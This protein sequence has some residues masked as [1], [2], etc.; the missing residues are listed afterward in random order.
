MA[1]STYGEYS[2]GEVNV[3]R[4]VLKPGDICIDVG[5]NIGAFTVPMAQ[6]VGKHGEVHAF[7]P[8]G[9]NIDLLCANVLQNDLF[10][11]IIHECA[12]SDRERELEVT[13]QDALH[14]Y[15]HPAINEGSVTVH[16]VPIDSLKLTRCKLIKIDVDRHE[17]QVIR[18]ARETIKRCRPIIYV[19]NEHD[20]LRQELVA[21][22]VELGY[23]LYW[24]KPFQFNADN[25]R[26]NDRN[27]FGNLVSIMNLCVP[28][29][30]GYEVKSLDEVSDYRDDD[31]MFDREIARYNKYVDRNPDDLTSRLMYA[32]HQN[33]MQRE[34]EAFAAL[35]ENLRREPMHQPSLAI[36]GFFALQ[37]GN[38]KEGWPA[39]ELRFGQPNRHQFGGDRT[40]S[41]PKWDGSKTN[42][43]LLIWS[44]QGFGDNIMFAR[45]FG[46][47]LKRAPMAFLEC[48]P[49][50]YELFDYSRVA[51]YEN[52]YRL[53]RTLPQYKLH[54]SICSLPHILNVDDEMIKIERPYLATDPL[55]VKNWRGQGN[56]RMGQTPDPM[57]GARIGLC[58]KGS[59]T[60]ERPYTR[61]VR[62][63]ALITTLGRKF[64]PIFPLNNN[65]QFE[66]FMMTAAAIKALDI[67]ITV[68]TSVA[69]LA[70]ALGVETWLLLSY[71]PDWRWGLKGTTSI[72]YP[73]MRIFRQPK[74][75]DWASVIE[76]VSAEL[77]RRG[78]GRT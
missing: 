44:E 21:E 33:L 32:H 15:S 62:P 23:R 14:A 53:G 41:V 45:F 66:S 13:R 10:N 59:A 46:E 35:A 6:L 31:E 28:D 69:H 61:D 74:F 55:L 2:E 36:K 65:G 77:E 5:A 43:P 7:E 56:F 37:R 34:D 63:E 4:K 49:E 71:D 67:V 52:L 18:G 58:H 57:I 75:R 20:D 38:W 9:P 24:H 11:V 51:G 26:K 64:G 30:E 68:D 19:E 16:G 50:L 1:L 76:E 29:E 73:T 22:L 25:W 70:G 78:Y 42:E 60:S 8:C 40:H 54:C 47:V 39:H 72:W 27:V 17:L 3:F 12:A 48:R